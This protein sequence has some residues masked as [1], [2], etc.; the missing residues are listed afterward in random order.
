MITN[1]RILELARE[2]LD[3]F[4][5]DFTATREQLLRFANEIYNEGHEDGWESRANAEYL[6][7][8]YPAG[9]IGDPQ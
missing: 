7:G 1:E 8:S 6:N 9:L 5:D 3:E 2:H 4:P